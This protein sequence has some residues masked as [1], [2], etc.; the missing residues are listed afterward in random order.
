MRVRRSELERPDVS[1]ALTELCERYDGCT[2]DQQVAHLLG[3]PAEGDASGTGTS[4]GSGT[5]Q[6]DGSEA[7]RRQPPPSKAG[8]VVAGSG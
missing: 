6:P 3:L 8:A 2:H 7:P 4:P 5:P 1:Q